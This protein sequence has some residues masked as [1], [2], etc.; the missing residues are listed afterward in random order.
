VFSVDDP[1]QVG[2]AEHDGAGKT[3]FETGV[4][5]HTLD[6]SKNILAE[7]EA[8]KVDKKRKKSI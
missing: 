6:G 1:F 2:P 4:S 8:T 7:S 5:D 3:F